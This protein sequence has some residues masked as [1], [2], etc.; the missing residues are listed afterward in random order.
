M[1]D[2]AKLHGFMD[3]MWN[4]Y[5]KLC[6]TAIEIKKLLEAKSDQ[7]I[8]DHIALRTVRHGHAGISKLASV[9]EGFGYVDSGDYHFEEKK[10]FAKHFQHP[11]PKLPKVFIS[12]LKI[13]EC[14]DYLQDI[15]NDLLENFQGCDG[16]LDS[17]HRGRSWEVDYEVYQK[18]YA[19]S[20]FAAWFY[21]H[22]FMPNHFTVFINSLSFVNSVE[23]LNAVLSKQGFRMNE[24]GGLVKGGSDVCLAQSSTMAAKVKVEFTQGEKEVPGCY[25]EFAKRFPLPSGELYQGFVASSADKIFESTNV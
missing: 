5:I 6:P 24:S 22:G 10:L 14:S 18:L 21:C 2:L 15:L 7:V 8:N 9:F 17:I 3:Q 20:E 25:M 11:D 1:G 13:E 12:E 16:S 19:E 4:S 23:E